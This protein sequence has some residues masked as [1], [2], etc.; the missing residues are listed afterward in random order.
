MDYSLLHRREYSPG[1]LDELPE[2]DLLLSAFNSSER[3]QSVFEAARSTQ[4]DWLIHSEYG[5][6]D[7]E[8]PA[9]GRV[10]APPNRDEAEFWQHYVDVTRLDELPAECRLCVDATGFMR[11]HLMFLLLLLRR[12]GFVSVDILYSDPKAYESGDKTEFSQGAVTE[13]RQVRGFEGAHLPDS[14]DN[15]L[16]V[17]GA[18]YD[19]G[20]IR[21]VAE[22]KRSA[23][24]IQMFGFPSLQPHM[25][26]ENRLRA[27]L[28]EES[29]SP[30][31]ASSLLFAA[32][33]DPF[34]V[35]QELHDC[36]ARQSKLGIANLYLSPL[37]TKAQ[38][39][40]FALFY[41]C[42]RVSGPTSIIFP[43]AESYSRETSVGLARVWLYRFELDWIP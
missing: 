38:V 35:A 14:G 1:S 28:A 31:P 9:T 25:Y 42:E 2:W 8:L 24:K 12:L 17:I 36:V 5:F 34:E 27:A 29:I 11:P 26:E 16:L 13:V 40:G 23:R 20:L 22:N 30:L 37:S 7:D 43:Y 39:L 4:K 19:D 41:L 21:R 10:I 6:S 33:N 15:D 18:G 3:V 32:A